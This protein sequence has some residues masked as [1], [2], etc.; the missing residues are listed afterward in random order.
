MTSYLDTHIVLWLHVSKK[1][2]LSAPAK[3]A[4]DESVLLISPIVL[5]EIQFLMERGRVTVEGPKIV[6]DLRETIG[7]EVCTAAFAAAVEEARKMIWT[8][9]PF[10]RL[11]AGHAAAARAPLIT[12]DRSIRKHYE[13][14]IW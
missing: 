9:D 10:D 8:R 12:K 1:D 5:L 7:L 2:M 3:A 13:R 14:A 6:E 4:L 11:I